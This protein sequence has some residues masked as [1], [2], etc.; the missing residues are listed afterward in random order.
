MCLLFW[1]STM[2]FYLVGYRNLKSLE[3]KAFKI[4][5]SLVLLFLLQKVIILR[6]RG[7]VRCLKQNK[8]EL[9]LPSTYSWSI[10]VTA[11]FFSFVSYRAS[12]FYTS[13]W[14]IVSRE[15]PAVTAVTVS[16]L[17]HSP[18]TESTWNRPH[19]WQPISPSTRTPH[20]SS[21]LQPALIDPFIFIRQNRPARL[22]HSILK[23]WY[24]SPH[25][26]LALR[27]YTVRAGDTYTKGR[28]NYVY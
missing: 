15:S 19:R 11:Y 20:L 6:I 14:L 22:T 13:V 2:D 21:S 17:C 8:S 24:D 3:Y 4:D 12:L 1:V 7:I 16:R 10:F 18:R 26:P 27:R 28:R 5:G 9:N 25:S 23:Y